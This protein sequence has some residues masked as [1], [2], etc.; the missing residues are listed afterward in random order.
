MLFSSTTFIYLFLPAVILVYYT[1]LRKRR[2]LQNVFLLAASLVFYAW[3]EPKFVFVMMAS[4]AVTW[5]LGLALDRNR[6]NRAAAKAIVCLGVCFHL[7]ILFV[8]KYLGF[9]GSI[10]QRMTGIRLNLP[11]LAMPIG[12]S[13]FTFQAM[14][15]VIDV[16]R[17]KARVQTNL[18]NVGLYISFFPQLI[19]GPI[20]RY[21]TVAEELTGRKENLDDFFGG[22]A[23]FVMGLAKKVLL[24]D[25]FAVLAD[26]AFST[27]RTAGTISFLFG[28]LGAV[29]FSLQSFFD[30]SGYSDMAIGMG[31]MFGFH[32]PE[33]FNYPYI[34]TSITEFWHRWHI[35]L[36]T[37]FRDY[38]YIPLG[39]SRCSRWRSLLNL[40]VVWGLTGLWHGASLK[41]LVWGLMFFALLAMER[42]TGIGKWKGK[43]GCALGWVYAIFF[44]LIGGVIFRARS[45]TD[46]Y[47]Y[48]KSL[49]WLNGNAFSDGLF[50]GWFRQNAVLLAVGAVLSTPAMR[51]LSERAGNRPAAQVLGAVGLC[52]LFVL[53][54]A[55]VVSSTYNPFIYFRF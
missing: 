5:L 47:V 52:C 42:S 10:L 41:Y 38:L 28:W 54:V 11:A 29:T 20:I 35:S 31:R 44:I 34:A 30:F 33:N 6:E 55:K 43:A 9:T 17:Q 7:G 16:Y 4:I 23:R 26:Q 25:S 49:L 39:G 21:E 2:F 13:F 24:A 18:L 27:V 3:G 45:L 48:L 1:V 15:Y 8:Y 14:S 50:S 37:W 32:F 51:R 36:G 12:I 40:L 46:A 22:F 19:A 53:T